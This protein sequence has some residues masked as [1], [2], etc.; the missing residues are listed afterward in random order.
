MEVNNMFQLFADKSRL[1]VQQREPLTG[2]SVNV[3]RMRFEF[4]PAWDGLTRTAVFRN[5]EETRSVLLDDTN[6]CWIPWEVLAQPFPPLSRL[7]VGVYGTRGEEIVLPTEWVDCGVIQSG[8]V[9]GECTQP[10]TP[11]VY[12]QILAETQEARA[13]TAQSCV[14]AAAAASSAAQAAERAAAASVNQPKLSEDGSWMVWDADTGAYVDTGLSAVGPEGKQGETGQQGRQGEKGEKGEK[15]DPGEQG[16]QGIQG[17]QGPQGLRGERGEQGPRGFPGTEVVIQETCGPSAEAVVDVA[18]PGTP[19]QAVSEIRLVQEGEGTP[20]LE[21]IRRIVGWD[22]VTLT[23][24]GE[25]ISQSLPEVVYGGSYD[26]AKGE[27]TV[28]HKLFEFAV[29]NMDNNDDYPGWSSI[30][31]SLLECFPSGSS[32]T[33]A[34]EVMNIGGMIGVNTRGK[35]TV[36]IPRGSYNLDQ[37]AWKEQY[38]DLIVQ[39]VFPLLEPRTVQIAPRELTALTGENIFSSD[40]GDTAVTY[41]AELKKYV[42]KKIRTLVNEKLSG[43]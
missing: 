21:N 3:C 12:Q 8:A 4:S 1:T 16:P 35:G 32:G 29:A 28:T 11:D 13:A 23:R 15:G 6:E 33:Y 31:E 10:P 17:E 2:G 24:N 5:G 18:A 43:S 40:T 25:S 22:K 26:W 41:Q 36:Y 30:G 37:A 19:L 9:P 38:P 27:L 14:D 20:S 34:D 39:M 42:D 7:H